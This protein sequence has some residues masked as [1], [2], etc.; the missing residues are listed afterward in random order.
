VL[1]PLSIAYSVVTRLRTAAYNKGLLK[2]TEL[3]APVISVGNITVGGTGKTP[4]VEKICR[5][6]SAESRKVCVL[7][8]GYR[9]ENPG[10]RVLVSDGTTLLASA[11]QA[12]DEPF[13]LAEKLIGTAAVVCDA[14]R[15]AA[16]TWAIENLDA[17]VFVLDDGFQH[18]QLKR[19]LDIVAIDATNPWGSN[20]LLPRGA[21]REVAGGLA[22]ADCVIITRTNQTKDVSLLET[23]IRKLLGPS[24]ILTSQ[25]Q[26]TGVRQV[27]GI[28]V[29]STAIPQPVLAFC[30]IGNPNSFLNQVRDENVQVANLQV[31]PDHYSYQQADISDLSRKAKAAGAVS[32]ITT[33]KD[34]V[35]VSTLQFD[36]P[37]YVLEIEILIN[38]EA[39]LRELIRKAISAP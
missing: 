8:R 18:L 10:N 6:L 1:S 35:K 4:L 17:D 30:A 5:I 36:L 37:C 31:F 39:A 2:T 9:R 12:G 15:A 3:P 24:P 28:T 16:G 20:H 21:L 25:M 7:T 33:A 14:N 26:T 23:E 34:A 13:L 32:L 19:D 22:R 29:S 11:S 27:K 38:E